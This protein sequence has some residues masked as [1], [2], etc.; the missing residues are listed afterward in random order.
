MTELGHCLDYTFSVPFCVCLISLEQD[1]FH[2]N[3]NDE[4]NKY[5][6]FSMYF[7]CK[8]PAIHMGQ[9]LIGVCTQCLHADRRLSSLSCDAKCRVTSTDAQKKKKEISG[10]LKL[11]IQ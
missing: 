5:T 8:S 3:K 9:D 11:L 7:T 6:S 10:L 1:R 2:C 4:D